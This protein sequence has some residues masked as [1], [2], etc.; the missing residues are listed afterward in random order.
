M[1]NIIDKPQPRNA[2]IDKTESQPAQNDETYRK[3]HLSTKIEEN[4][5]LNDTLK[6]VKKTRNRNKG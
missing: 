2:K 5:G 1:I 6:I 4:V 3:S